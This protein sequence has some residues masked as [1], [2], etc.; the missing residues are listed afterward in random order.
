MGFERNAETLDPHRRVAFKAD[1]C[2]ANP[3]V[4]ALSDQTRKEMHRIIFRSN[5]G[6]I[7]DSP[8]FLWFPGLR[9]HD[10]AKPRNG[11]CYVLESLSR[12]HFSNFGRFVIGTSGQLHGKRS[13]AYYM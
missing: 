6:R 9:G 12:F 5:A 10:D 4:I 8:G 7:K 11:E 2:V 13:L 1:A 3:R